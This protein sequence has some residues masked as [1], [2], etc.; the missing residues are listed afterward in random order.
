M[1]DIQARSSQHQGHICRGQ[2]ICVFA[3]LEISGTKDQIKAELSS[4][5]AQKMKSPFQEK[6]YSVQTRLCL[7]DNCPTFK[8]KEVDGGL[9]QREE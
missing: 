2:E 4:S 7:L 9:D 5:K 3:F 6:T 8:A 1:F